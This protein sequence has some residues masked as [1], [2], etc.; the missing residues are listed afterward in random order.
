[1]NQQSLY[2]DEL[3]RMVRYRSIQPNGAIHHPSGWARAISEPDEPER[4]AVFG[5]VT[6][7]TIELDPSYDGPLVELPRI[8]PEERN[9][10][11]ADYFRMM[12]M[13]PNRLT[14]ELDQ[15]AL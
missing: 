6:A 10:H 12:L 13:A 15:E 8:E 14:I 1:M 9:D 3:S 2:Q 5:P 4:I 7:P 11:E